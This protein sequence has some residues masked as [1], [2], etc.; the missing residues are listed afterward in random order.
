MTLATG[1]GKRVELVRRESGLN[2]VDFARRVLSATASA[3]Q[4]ARIENEEI[5]PQPG[6]LAKIAE[7]GNV[8]LDWLTK[9][10]CPLQPRDVVRT[11]GLGERIATARK[12]KGLTR[13]ALAQAA[14][15]GGSSKN[16]SRLETGEHRPRASTVVRLA[17]TLKVSP[18]YLA[19]GA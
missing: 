11:A 14:K 15:L 13:L 5:T 9:G 4:L 7:I 10:E 19:Y 8:S 16:I 1:F 12:E 17:E 2:P 18:R 6:T 3:K